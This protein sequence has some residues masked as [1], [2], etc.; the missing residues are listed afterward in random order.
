[1]NLAEYDQFSQGEAATVG[2]LRQVHAGHLCRTV[3]V[4]RSA[5]IV[6]E[7]AVPLAPG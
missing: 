1:M 7:G 5:A 3:T 4:P 6:C 2:F